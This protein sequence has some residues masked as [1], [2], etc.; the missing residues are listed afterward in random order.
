MADEA[1][2]ADGP[3][4]L[5][6]RVRSAL[7]S[8]DLDAI[9]DLLDPDARWGAPEGPSDTDCRNRDEVIAWWA[10]ARA[11]GVRAVVTEVTVGTGTLLVGLE[12]TGTPAAGEA[13][14]TAGRWQVLTV[15]GDRIAD[16][17]GFED[18]AAA[19]ARAGVPA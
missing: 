4:V 15:Q 9:R 7:E 2:A 8:G 3:A 14:G 6:G 10:G 17:R 11:A 19:A 1:S 5:A 12:V 18:R 13:G 16:I